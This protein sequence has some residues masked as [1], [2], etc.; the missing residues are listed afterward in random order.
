MTLQ[1]KSATLI[2]HE[3]AGSG[4]P[5]RHIT[6]VLTYPAGCTLHFEPN[7][8]CLT[9]RDAGGQVLAA[10][11]GLKRFLTDVIEIG[12]EVTTEAS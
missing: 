9:V 12:P 3:W 7:Q 2:R 1:T 6:E 10:F 4:K 8:Q 5:A 11:V